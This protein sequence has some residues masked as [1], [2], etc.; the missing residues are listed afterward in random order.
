[1]SNQFVERAFTN[2]LEKR[3]IHLEHI[4][5]DQNMYNKTYYIYYKIKCIN[6]FYP[7]K[8][9]PHYGSFEFLPNRNIN[10]LIEEISS[11]INNLSQNLRELHDNKELHI[12]FL[13][14]LAINKHQLLCNDGSY[15]GFAS[16]TIFKKLYRDN[17]ESILDAIANF[18]NSIFI[19]L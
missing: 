3:N 6:P 5:I 10:S 15:A 4:T 16:K 1:M 9:L 11:D 12:D 17:N 7:S 13:E 18:D 19:N 14:K 8:S 2:K